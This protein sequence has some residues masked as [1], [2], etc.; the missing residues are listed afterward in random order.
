MWVVINTSV[1]DCTIIKMMMK[2]I[3]VHFSMQAGLSGW[4]NNTAQGDIIEQKETI[5]K[6]IT[7][8]EKIGWLHENRLPASLRCRV[9]VQ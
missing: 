7:L 9:I 6:K 3:K 5:A 1:K 4:K 2:Q 8:L